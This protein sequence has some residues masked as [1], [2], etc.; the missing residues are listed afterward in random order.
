MHRHYCTCEQSRVLRGVELSKVECSTLEQNGVQQS[1]RMSGQIIFS[2]YKLFLDTFESWKR[3]RRKT[4]IVSPECL[5]HRDA[6][7][8]LVRG[9]RP[10]HPHPPLA[11]KK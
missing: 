3:K 6:I 9:S 7:V 11:L 4:L 10:P 5:V 8:P 2:A 1:E